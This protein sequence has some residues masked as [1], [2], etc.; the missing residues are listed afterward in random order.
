MTYFECDEYTT[1]NVGDTVT[2]PDLYKPAP[3]WRRLW[4]W[5][6]R[7]P[8][9]YELQPYVIASTVSYPPDPGGYIGISLPKS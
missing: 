1:L 2:F 4:F 7:E 5:V 8:Y 9:P 3:L 6:R